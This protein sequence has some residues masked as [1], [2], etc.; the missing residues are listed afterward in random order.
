MPNIQVRLR[1]GSATDHDTTSGGFT[2]AE[3]EV[4]V[5][6]TND[7]LRVHDG[8]T[9][10]GIR[11]AK[12]S[13]L[14]G[15]A[16]GSVTTA[17][18]ADD[19]VT[20]AK[21]DFDQ[22]TIE[23]ESSEGQSGIASLEIVGVSGAL[24]DL[25]QDPESDYDAR[26][27]NQTQQT[28]LDSKD[29]VQIR[30]GTALNTA[31]NIHTDGKVQVGSSSTPSYALDMAGDVNVTGDFKVN[32]T[33]L[34]VGAAP[35]GTVTA[36]AGSSAPTGYLLCYGQQVSRTTESALF[37]VI[38]TTYGV[39]DGSTTF[40]LPDLRGRVIG[41][42]D[43]M[44]G[45]SAN[46]LTGFS[47]GLNGDV[48]GETGGSERH[49]LTES[50]IPAHDHFTIASA[51]G[52]TGITLSTTNSVA[53]GTS[54]GGD[55]SYSLR[56]DGSTTADVGLSSETGSGNAHNNVQPTIILNYIIKT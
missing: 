39:G 49:T 12:H 32:G 33:N 55:S 50:Q 45:T 2:G 37:A 30:T 38:G 13:E 28:R 36:F 25:R 14:G 46:R 10:G 47:G 9:A 21:T 20:P 43:D 52:S 41:G 24:I 42:Q 22:L 26:L 7:T 11:L 53:A 29:A 8:S 15:L 40:N 54:F 17:K 56:S 18:L 6:T 16:D 4:T 34:S 3:G 23:A 1:R 5:D 19:A 31:L 27:I 44:G 48:L 35:T 51:S